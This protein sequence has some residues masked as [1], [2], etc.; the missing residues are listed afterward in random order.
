MILAVILAL[1]IVSCGSQGASGKLTVFAGSSLTDAFGDIAQAFER[2]E[3]GATIAINFASSSAL[4]AQLEQGA[5]ADIFASADDVQ[6][7]LAVLSG[8][9]DGSPMSF[10]TNRLA[11][12]TD[13]GNPKI[14]SLQDLSKPGLR[15]ILG[16]KQ[17]PIGT[18]TD[19]ALERMANHPEYGTRFVEQLRANVVSYA[20]SARQA[21]ATV[22]MS[23]ADAAIAYITD[24]RASERL[25]GIVFPEELSGL[26]SYPIAL[27]EG[28][29]AVDLARLFMA[30]VGSDVGIA[31]LRSHGFGEP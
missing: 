22:E 27:V 25:K 18:Y 11:V 10:A 20:L 24:A 6:M 1:G 19:N 15:L 17:T 4:R 7:G 23:E 21:V 16:A 30:F 29:N 5:G 9:I 31:I 8:V 3:G 28:S 13:V 14:S 12:V 26:A 2:T